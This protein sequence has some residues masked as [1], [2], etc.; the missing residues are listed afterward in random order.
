[1]SKMLERKVDHL[2][3]WGA[4]VTLQAAVT[5]LKW[6]RRPEVPNASVPETQAR[7]KAAFTA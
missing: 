1:V 2:V 5:V 6:M 3:L 7:A 4:A